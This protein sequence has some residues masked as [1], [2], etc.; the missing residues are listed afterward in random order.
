MSPMEDCLVEALE[1]ED[2][3]ILAF[4]H[5]HAGSRQWHFYVSNTAD[6][7][8][9]INEALAELPKLPISLE[10]IDDPEWHEMA[11][12]LDAVRER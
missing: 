12:V 7:G 10:V 4:V 5:T 2:A 6:L 11:M 3:G 9:L 1:T 8:E